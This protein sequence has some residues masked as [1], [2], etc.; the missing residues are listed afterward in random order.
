MRGLTCRHNSVA[1]AQIMT[2]LSEDSLICPEFSVSAGL[3]FWLCTN[4]LKLQNCGFFKWHV[5]G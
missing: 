3:A 4:Y 2:I 5:F 1:L